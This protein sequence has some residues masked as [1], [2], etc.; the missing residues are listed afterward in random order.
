MVITRQL[1]IPVPATAAIKKACELYRELEK[2]IPVVDASFYKDLVCPKN[3]KEHPYDR[4]FKLKE[5]Y[6]S[7]MIKHLLE[8]FGAKKQDWVLDPFLGSGST[9]IGARNAGV[10][11]AGFEVNPFL[12]KLSAVKM[13]GS[14]DAAKLSARVRSLFT[15]V[16]EERSIEIGMPAL[17]ITKKLFREQLD[18]LLRIKQE[19]YTE[20]DEHVRD[21]LLLGL[22]CILERCSYARKDGNGLKYPPS[23]KPLPLVDTLKKQYQLMIADIEKQKGTTDHLIMNTDSRR[24]N[25]KKLPSDKSDL[26]HDFLDHA[27]F[28]MFSPPYANCFDYT[29]VYKIELWML[30]YIKDY[31]QLKTLRES[32]VSSHLNKQYENDFPSTLP[33]LDYVVDLIPWDS[34]WG[35]HKMKAMVLHYFDDMKAVFTRLRGIL[36][37]NGTLVCIVGNS[38][39]GNVPI[40]TDLFLAEYLK[41]LGFGKVEI[42]AARLLG[43]SSQ[44]QKYLSGNPYL[45][46]SLVIAST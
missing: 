32:S 28:T 1:I 31:A 5:G 15:A 35:K 18:T 3:W 36:G 40:A 38:A 44:Q 8:E 33:D 23:K 45:R 27:K 46:E 14:Y 6:S 21:F 4:W 20:I 19:I 11:G 37:D 16:A 34:T 29:E 42:R 9:L 2:S 26:V 24:V 43:T 13:H 12:A 25:I 7:F 22:G 17:T 10:K 30:D 39:Y 41:E